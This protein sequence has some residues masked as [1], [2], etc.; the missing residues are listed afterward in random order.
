M[1]SIKLPDLRIEKTFFKFWMGISFVFHTLA[2]YFSVGYHSADE[3]FQ[4]LEFLS[5]KLSGLPPLAQLPVEFPERMRPFTQVGLYWVVVKVSQF[6]GIDNPFTW[7]FLIRLLTSWI[8]WLSIVALGYCCLNWFKEAKTRRFSIL[9]LA[10]LWCLPALHSRP[11]SESLGGSAFVLAFSL[12]LLK[13]ARPIRARLWEWIPIGMIFGL[14]FESRFQMGLMIAGFFGW[15]ILASKIKL[16]DR[17]ITASTCLSG[18]LI[19]ILIGRWIDH[20]GYGDWSLSPVNY[21]GYN[22]VR[23]EVSRYGQAPWWDLFRMSFT[24]SWP[25]IGLALAISAIVAWVRNPEHPITWSHV[26]FFFVHEWIAHKELRFFFPIAS[27][28]PLLVTLSL[29]SKKARRLFSI[30]PAA[31]AWLKWPWYFLLVNNCLALVMFSVTPIARTVQYYEAV[32]DRLPPAPEKFI[33]YTKGRD[34]FEVLGT[35][36]YFYRPVQLEVRHFDQY[37]ELATQSQQSSGTFWLFS[38]GFDAP[39]ELATVLPQCQ[40]SFRTLPSWVQYFNYMDWISRANVWSLYRC[41][42]S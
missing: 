4:I 20:W 26:P 25:F 30:S 15:W 29:Y 34:P 18:L 11:S 14:S 41:S 40:R 5:H 9:A 16:Q 8:G 32:Y 37:S 24:E 42:A 2:A 21:F 31:W 10:L 33:L 28:G 22:I 1:K 7:A 36:I 39:S 13:M 23:G 35:P 12:V 38:P 3:Q 17:L 27:A 19:F 6:L